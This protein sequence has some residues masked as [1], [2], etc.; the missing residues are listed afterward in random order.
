MV[1]EKEW[2]SLGERVISRPGWKGSG[3]FTVTLSSL[4][5]ENS[6]NQLRVR[7]KSGVS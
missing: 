2:I 3:S 5:E 7:T 6:L 4:D 1:S